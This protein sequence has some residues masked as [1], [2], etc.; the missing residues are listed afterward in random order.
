MI[1]GCY[2]YCAPPRTGKST[3]MVRDIC[4][5]IANYNFQ[6]VDVW[7]N[8]PIFIEGIHCLENK[9][10]IQA[11]LEMKARK[12]RHKI[13]AFDEAGQELRARESMNKTQIEVVTSAW[14]FPKRDIILLYGSN[15]GNSA[16]IILRLATFQTIMPQYIKGPTWKEDRMRVTVLYNYEMRA[17]Q[18]EVCNFWIF[19]TLFNTLAPIQ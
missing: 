13:I 16:D 12:E 3:L 4:K 11:M 2:E 10:L 1:Q 18:W 5:L 8:F 19:Q 14:Q 6:P 17:E 9:D 15:P 7:A